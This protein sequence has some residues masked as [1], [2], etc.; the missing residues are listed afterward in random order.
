MHGCVNWLSQTSQRQQIVGGAPQEFEALQIPWPPS[1]AINITHAEA[2]RSHTCNHTQRHKHTH[3][4]THTHT[5]QS[6]Q[7]RRVCCFCRTGSLLYR[8]HSNPTTKQLTR[9][10]P[11][12]HHTNTPQVKCAVVVPASLA[13]SPA[14]HSNALGQVN[15]TSTHQPLAR[16]AII[17]HS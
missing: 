16:L 13:L 1:H 10:R 17:H 4:H 15:A 7:A 9:T 3:T 11:L 5:H 12:S 6:C 8:L 2:Q 14:N